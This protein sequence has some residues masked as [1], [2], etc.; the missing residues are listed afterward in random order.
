[1]LNL[2][3]SD[4]YR[5]TRPRCLR[6]SL[7]Q[8]GL[9]LAL[10]Y[11]AYATFFLVLKIPQVSANL[12]ASGITMATMTEFST[13]TQCIAS[14]TGNLTTLCATFM[15]VEL[16]LADLKSG[17]AKSVLSARTGRLS[18]IVG[19]IAFAGVVSAIVIA[20]AS[21]LVGLCCI[22]VG[23]TFTGADTL[24]GTLAWIAGFWLNTWALCVLSLVMVYATRISPVCYIV[25]FCLCFSTFPQ[26]LLGLAHS[27]GGILSFLEPIAPALETLAAWMPSSA[28]SNLGA[29]GQIV[30][31]TSIDIWSASSRALTIDPAPQAVLTGIIWIAA[32]SALVLAIARR[33][34][35]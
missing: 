21:A 25:A 24:A 35:V 30:L 31:S 23:A 27:S 13:P 34:D 15:T 6:G 26:L 10:I 32:A 20:L 11:L 18:Y 8:Y 1:M 16:A 12:A 19:K 7:W 4:L 28:L 9:V 33:R 22:A 17:F 5:I 29:G 2:I 14:M 3:K